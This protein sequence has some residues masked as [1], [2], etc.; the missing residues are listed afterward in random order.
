MPTTAVKPY[1]LACL[2]CALAAAQQDDNFA[3]F[4]SFAAQDAVS[5]DSNG[6]LLIQGVGSSF[7]QRFFQDVAF[8]YRSTGPDASL[9]YTST[10]SSQGVCR[11][12][13]YFKECDNPFFNATVPCVNL[14]TEEECAVAIESDPGV[15]NQNAS[16]GSDCV[17][18]CGNCNLSCDGDTC[19]TTRPVYVDFGATDFILTDED[20]AEYP[21]I[22]LY[23]AVAG[24]VVPIFNL[25]NVPALTLTKMTLSRIFRSNI[26]QWGDPAIIETNPMFVMQ[27]FAA[28]DI[29]VH[30]RAENSGT[31]SIWKKSLASFDS[32]FRTQIGTAPSADWPNANVAKFRSNYGLAA[33]VHVTPNSIG[34]SVLAE[35]LFDGNFGVAT[36]CIEQSFGPC[37][38]VEATFSSVTLAVVERGLDFG[39]NE[40]S[41]DRLTAD[42]HNARGRDVWPIVGYSYFIIRKET[43]RE[44][45]TCD[46]KRAL[47]D[48][49]TWFYEN[50]NGQLETMA[51]GQGFAS[52]P[53][54]T[55]RTVLRRVKG[56][57]YCNGTRLAVKDEEFKVNLAVTRPLLPFL[58]L[59]GRVY[60]VVDESFLFSKEEANEGGIVPNTF[61]RDEFLSNQQVG[62]EPPFIVDFRSEIAALP[63]DG[64]YATNRLFGIA[65]IVTFNLCEPRD[66]QS[67]VYDNLELNMTPAII[68]GILSGRITAWNDPDLVALNANVLDVLGVALPAEDIIVYHNSDAR[69]APYFETL[70]QQLVGSCF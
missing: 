67:C 33:S 1:A 5:L 51:S 15:C 46:N 53:S 12:E 36:L 60:T 14:L 41:P 65:M 34:Y 61:N 28:G 10:S 24:G 62:L 56:D 40:D 18:A 44:G 16:E 47:F 42:L 49:L 64:P 37:Q 4:E 20:Y 32:T 52:L 68:A 66:L 59:T 27:L 25:A 31:T 43:L 9:T 69:D 30:V 48:F 39:N 21:D 11:V 35:V 50:E 2:A 8:A 3:A 22:Q 58:E 13:D 63:A 17:L 6:L 19:D 23:P 57:L 38:T 7:P 70:F 54:T 45:A 29:H 55:A 26:T